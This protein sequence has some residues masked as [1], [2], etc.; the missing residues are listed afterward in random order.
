MNRNSHSISHGI[1]KTKPWAASSV[2][3]APRSQCGGRGFE[4][5]AVHQPSLLGSGLCGSPDL[6]NDDLIL[7]AQLEK[8]QRD[9]DQRAR[10]NAFFYVN[11]ERENWTEDDFYA[12]G[13]LFIEEHILN[14]Q[15]NIFQGRDPKKM[16]I[17]EIG[18]GVGR[19]TRALAKVFGEVHAVDVSGEMISRAREK[20]AGVPNVHLY[21]N[22]G[23]DLDVLPR[24]KYDFACSMIVFQ[25]IPSFDVIESYIRDTGRLLRDGALFKFQV[26][27]GCEE[28]PT[29]DDTWNGVSF[30][31][32]LARIVANRNGFEL[33][34]DHG[35]GDQYYW[36]WFFRQPWQVRWKADVKR[37]VK[38]QLIQWFGKAGVARWTR[39]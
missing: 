10:E 16:R 31:Q 25:H 18:C 23:R 29:A 36:L 1:L 3:R 33:R 27:G 7:R 19:L 13:E 34:Y 11:T 14:D 4:S 30:T 39:K 35:A 9:W 22:N 8:M 38:W 6:S 5:H 21:Q 20:L 37:S 17:I 28:L 26:Q 2:G 24:T 15:H 32:E 12:S